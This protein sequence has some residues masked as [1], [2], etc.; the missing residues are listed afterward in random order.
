MNLTDAKRYAGDLQVTASRDVED[1]RA[2]RQLADEDLARFDRFHGNMIRLFGPTGAGVAAVGRLRDRAQ[3]RAQAATDR[4]KHADASRGIASTILG[5]IDQ[6][7]SIRE[8]GQAAGGL[9]Q[10]ETYGA[11]PNTTTR[12]N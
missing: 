6:H 2:A 1:A 8:R 10:R 9:A 4:A 5:L 11:G 7:L 3:Q 12:T